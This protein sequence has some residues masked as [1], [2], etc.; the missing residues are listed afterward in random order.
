MNL[1]RETS[2]MMKSL[3]SLLEMKEQLDQLTGDDQVLAALKRINDMIYRGACHYVSPKF[4]KKKKKKCQ[5]QS[6]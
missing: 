1:R 3:L 5:Q 4:K 6:C 2:N